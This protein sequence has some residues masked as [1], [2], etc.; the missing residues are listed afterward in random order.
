MRIHDRHNLQ[1]GVTLSGLLV[2]LFLLVVVAL[3]GMK[4]IPAYMEFATAKNAIEA[5]ARERNAAT[6]AEVRR[7]FD[8]RAAIDDIT[9]V[10]A[11]DLGITKQ[12]NDMV[13]SFSYRKEVPLFANV[14]LYMDFSA[15]SGGQ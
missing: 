10:R 13:I 1:R 2:W 9:A 11:A 5:I 12:G 4:L 8:S 7:A 15:T 6:P 14:G 3:L